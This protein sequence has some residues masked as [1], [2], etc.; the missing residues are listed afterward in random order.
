MIQE[1][2]DC[3]LRTKDHRSWRIYLGADNTGTEFTGNVRLYTGLN[4]GNAFGRGDLFTYQYTCDPTIN[5][6]QAHFG[7]YVAFLPWRHMVTA[8]GGYAVSQPDKGPGC[9][10]EEQAGQASIRYIIPFKP[11]YTWLKQEF[12]VGANWKYTNS[13]TFFV[14]FPT[15]STK[16]EVNVLDLMVV[17]SFAYEQLQ[18]AVTF[19]LEGHGSPGTPLSHQNNL[20][21]NALRRGAKAKYFYTNLTLGE[22]YEFK[23]KMVLAGLLRLQGTTAALLPMLQFGLGGYDSVRGYPER[24]YLADN[25]LC[26]NFELRAPPFQPFRLRNHEVIFLAFLDYGLGHN[27]KPEETL[28]STEWL[29][30]VGPGLRYRVNQH[31]GLRI[32]YGFRLHQLP[33]TTH[34]L[35]KFHLGAQLTY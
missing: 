11:M 1:T 4:L 33:A 12:N 20:A 5:L 6:F 32:D 19:S 15:P 35:G 31:V 22:E 2:V 34:T 7:Q 29:M 21:Y 24:D 28:A 10:T 9:Q 25:A 18:N 27:L 14:E 23:N 13:N 16:S 30:S 17:Y 26:T 3:E 8:Y